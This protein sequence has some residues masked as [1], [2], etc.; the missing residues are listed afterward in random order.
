MIEAVLKEL[1]TASG[2]DIVLAAGE[3]LAEKIKSSHDIKKL[4]V[5][6]GEFFIDF[7][8][9]AEQLFQDMALVLSKENMTRLANEMKGYSGY[10]LKKRLLN[11][12]ISLMD[13]YDIPREY[14][15]FYAN[16]ILFT[17]LD[18][19]P[20]VAP[21]QYDRYFQS[22]WKEEQEQVLNEIKQKI[23]RVNNEISSA[24]FNVSFG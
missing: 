5:E 1:A 20:E 4:F 6:A 7:E 24:F 13:R 19:L 9:Q 2:T 23:E 8:P 16:S 18:Q 14:A 21:Q 10:T 11:S 15:T 3:H 22:E 17:I 12:L